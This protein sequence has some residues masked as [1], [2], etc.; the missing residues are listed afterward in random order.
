LKAARDA[1]GRMLDFVVIP[2][3]ARREHDGRRLTLSY[4]N[5]IFAN[6]GLVV[7]SFG[8]PADEH[9]RR[10]FAALYPDRRIIQIM[11][12]DLVIGGG[13]IHC[14]TQQEPA[15]AGRGENLKDDTD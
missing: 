3:P 6:G 9:A 12:D 8:D 10:A 1:K 15:P 4:V 13:G 5:F 7:P 11:A 14:I 2:Q